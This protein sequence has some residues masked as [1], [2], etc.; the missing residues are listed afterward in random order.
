MT[1]PANALYQSLQQALGPQYR[2]ERELGRGGMGVVFLAT[3]LT[4]DRQV[5]VKV[6]HPDLSTNRTIATRF[7][8][9]ARTVAKLR[10]PNI[11]A[12]HTAGEAGDQL[13]YVMDYCRGETLRQRLMRNGALPESIALQIAADISQALDAAAEAGIIHRDLKPENILLEGPAEAPHAL[14]TDFGIARLVE[15]GIG[16]HTNPGH[17]MGTPAYMSPEQAAGQ[18]FDARSDLYSLGIVTYEMLAGAPPFAGPHRLV[19][20]QQI[21]DVP[22]PIETMRPGLGLAAAAA[23]T[24]ALEKAPEDRWQSGRAFRHALLGD[25]PT[26]PTGTARRSRRPW[27]GLIAGLAAA[28]LALAGYFA[29]RSDGPPSDVNPRQSLLVLPFD[30]LRESSNLAWL[31]DGAVNMLTLALSQWRDLA[32]VDQNRVHDLLAVEHHSDREPIGLELARKLARRAGVWTVVL[33][34]F[35]QVGDSL[36]LVARTYDVASGRRL[37]VVQVDGAAVEDVRPLFD[38]LAAKLLDLTGAPQG[39]RSSLSAVTT[40]SLESYRAYL[41]GIEALNH[42]RLNEAIQNLQRAVAI[43]TTFSLAYYKLALARGWIAGITDSV[44]RDWILRASRTS[45]RLPLRE[46]QLAEAYRALLTG[47]LQQGERQY[48]ALV[49]R[50]QSDPDAWYGLADAAFHDGFERYDAV[51]LTRSLRAFKRVLAIDSNYT[52]AY[53]HITALLNDASRSNSWLVLLDSDSL[54]WSD[55]AGRTLLDSVRVRRARMRARLQNVEVAREWTRL[56]PNTA[57]AHYALYEALLASENVPA[58]LQEAGQ[59]R[60][61]IP[62][63]VQPLAS[64]LEARAEM[65]RKRYPEAMRAVRSALDHLDPAALHDLDFGRELT[66]TVVAGANALSYFGDLTT[67]SRVLRLGRAMREAYWLPMDTTLGPLGVPSS[68]EMVRQGQLFAAAGGPAT[69]LRALWN[70]AATGARQAKPAARA[71]ASLPGLAAAVG[72]AVGPSNDTNALAEWKGLSGIPLPPGAEAFMAAARGDSAAARAYLRHGDTL[73]KPMMRRLDTYDFALGDPRPLAA[74]TYFQLGDYRH[75]VET[76]R[77]FVPD[78][79]STQNFDP[80]WALVPRVRLLLGMAYERLGDA[81]AAA[82]AYRDVIDQWS[83][84]DPA[85]TPFVQQARAGMIRVRGIREAN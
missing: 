5:A 24:H 25:T 36:H 63:S 48:S 75:V 79:L 38:D 55:S 7:L 18:E 11:V 56:Q 78:S 30:N 44:G 22:P 28:G 17:V 35:S 74:Q 37:D 9:E 73:V 26:P 34:D 42:W 64:F 81:L 8:A 58:A 39:V 54:A 27:I 41:Q 72:L 61:L 51:T 19:I 14:L 46:R 1:S 76:L 70:Q 68:W 10:H 45:E 32:V 16:D 15:G 20:S 77:D 31:G 83:L 3:D 52:L 65:D 50:D 12:I 57:R 23:I 67:A 49:S 2:L 43:D 66:T 29:L 59:V 4:L 82:Q 6:V 85:L 71:S 62:N 33:G 13:F 80:R 60:A 47:D 84:A 53:E 69:T 40:W 21:M